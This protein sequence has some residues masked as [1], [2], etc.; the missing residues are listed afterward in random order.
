MMEMVANLAVKQ[1]LHN[2]KEEIHDNVE[3]ERIQMEMNILK[4]DNPL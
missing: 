4:G 1:K 3:L 2:V